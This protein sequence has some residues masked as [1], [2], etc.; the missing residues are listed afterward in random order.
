MTPL[1]VSV[2]RCIILAHAAPMTEQT[3]P[4]VLS[5]PSAIPAPG[6][7]CNRRRGSLGS[8]P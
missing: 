1:R 5:L 4:S 2:R 3:P 7:A 6:A 8:N